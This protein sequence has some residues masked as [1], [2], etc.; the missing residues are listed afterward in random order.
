MIKDNLWH[1]EKSNC[2]FW[3][4]VMRFLAG[5][6]VMWR[7]SDLWP[8]GFHV[9]WQRKDGTVFSYSPWDGSSVGWKRSLKELFF[10]GY[11]KKH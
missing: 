10:S 5:G 8:G 2:L 6:H 11:V 7:K 9:L 4:C 1:P 3:A